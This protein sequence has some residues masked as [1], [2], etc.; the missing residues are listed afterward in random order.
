M[1]IELKN[2]K[3]DSIFKGTNLSK[4]E[5]EILR[6]INEFGFCEIEQI[7]KKFNI[8]KSSAYSYVQHLLIRELL[9]SARVIRYQPRAYYVTAKGVDLLKLDL[10]PIRRIPLSVYEHQV[11][12]IE[13]YFLLTKMYPQASWVT[14]RRLLRENFTSGK[15][16]SEHLP[17]GALILL[18]GNSYAIEVERSSK[19][20]ERLKS[21]L[22]GYGVQNT[23]KEAW[24]FCSK[25]VLPLVR[26]L[27]NNV[28][29]IKVFD[30]SEFSL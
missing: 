16:K 10:P 17:D 19:T 2:K 8:R 15:N 29:Y 27:A 24:Y 1:N 12:V 30:M 20:R 25:S 22:H 14:E 13:V 6:F 3:N 7:I 18:E 11:A 28:P 26:D 21:I 9:V 23:Y 4:I 5:I